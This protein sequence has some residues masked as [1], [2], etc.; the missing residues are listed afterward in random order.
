MIA[1]SIPLSMTP[2]SSIVCLHNQHLTSDHC[3]FISLTRLWQH[4]SLLQAPTHVLQPIPVIWVTNMTAWFLAW[5]WKGCKGFIAWQP[6]WDRI[7]WTTYPL[8]SRWTR[9]L[10]SYS[11]FFQELT[12]IIENWEHQN[13]ESVTNS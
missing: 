3:A 5:L 4:Q 9:F 13:C 8:A 11:S 7:L 6:I 12:A 2:F 10:C 1:S